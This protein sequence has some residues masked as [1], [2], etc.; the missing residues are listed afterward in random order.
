LAAIE[1]QQQSMIKMM[2]TMMQGMQNV[3][4]NNAS[5]KSDISIQL[6]I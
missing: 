4:L 1:R 6:T 2:Q 5:S 3:S